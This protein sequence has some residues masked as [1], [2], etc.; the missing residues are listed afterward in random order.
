MKRKFRINAETSREIRQWIQLLGSIGG[1]G[2]YVYFSAKFDNEVKNR[3]NQEYIRQANKAFNS[4]QKS[5]WSLNEIIDEFHASKKEEKMMEAKHSKETELNLALMG[6]E[7][8]VKFTKP[9]WNER[10][11]RYSLLKQ[12]YEND[13]YY[14]PDYSD[15]RVYI[16]IIEN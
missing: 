12:T 16:Y 13:G 4:I 14:M 10:Y 6:G 3:K 2:A 7:K 1:L 15:T 9:E 11:S 5:S 8:I